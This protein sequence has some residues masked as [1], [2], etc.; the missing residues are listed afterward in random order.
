MNFFEHTIAI[1]HDYFTF[2]FAFRS[3]EIATFFA[4]RVTHTTCKFL[5]VLLSYKIL[6]LTISQHF[7]LVKLLLMPWTCHFFPKINVNIMTHLREIKVKK[8]CYKMKCQYHFGV[9]WI[10]KRR[11]LFLYTNIFIVNK[12]EV[13]QYK[14]TEG[15]RY[16][17]LPCST[18]FLFSLNF[19]Y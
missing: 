2:F 11:V 16:A 12:I 13:N 17:R 6:I 4:K 8:G 15:Y 5:S 7:H 3:N 10:Y 1:E 9:K 19:I 14:A 18:L